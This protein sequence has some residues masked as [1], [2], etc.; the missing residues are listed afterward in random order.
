MTSRVFVDKALPAAYK[1]LSAVALDV[2]DQ[3]AQV[4]LDR[5]VM[6]LVNVRVSQMNR[7][8]FCLDLHTR[9][10]R[11]AGETDRRLAVLPAWRDA[12]VFSDV[13][14]A[15]L[16]IAETV[17]SVAGE[18][19]PDEAYERLRGILGDEKVAVLVWAAI[20]INAFNRISILSLHPLPKE[21]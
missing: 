14:R 2:K 10:A 4:G 5:I 15:A 9:A 11:A 18:H 12:R 20:A 17:T 8:V 21:K 19:I 6:E 13:E 7:C 16:E 1:H 3:A